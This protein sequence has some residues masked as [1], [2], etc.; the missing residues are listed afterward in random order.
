M[1]QHSW[2]SSHN[3]SRTN[4]NVRNCTVLWLSWSQ[5]Q[6]DRLSGAYSTSI[7]HH[8][9]NGN[10]AFPR[11]RFVMEARYTYTGNWNTINGN[12]YHMLYS[13]EEHN[14]GVI[15]KSC[16]ICVQLQL[17]SWTLCSTSTILQLQTLTV[18]YVDLVAIV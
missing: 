6:T 14:R 2:T 15:V 11:I 5:V 16:S 4:F 7:I 9:L 1:G 18:H 3:S 8:S 12:T 10:K 13:I 17:Q